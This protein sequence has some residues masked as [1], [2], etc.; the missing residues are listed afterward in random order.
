[1]KILQTM[2][3]IKKTY[4]LLIIPV[5]VVLWLNGLLIHWLLKKSGRL[6]LT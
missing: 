2:K 3:F 5:C 4:V 1:M 6:D